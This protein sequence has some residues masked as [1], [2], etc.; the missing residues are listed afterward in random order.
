[1]CIAIGDAPLPGEDLDP[2]P[3]GIDS[4]AVGDTMIGMYYLG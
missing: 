3:S 4:M 2:E 1:M